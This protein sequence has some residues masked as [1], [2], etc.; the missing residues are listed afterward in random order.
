MLSTLA[1]VLDSTV[2]FP[3]GVIQGSVRGPLLYINDISKSNL[4]STPFL[5]SYDNK[6]V[7]LFEA[8]SFNSA[9]Q[10]TLEAF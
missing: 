1:A 8:G 4:H 6:I 5:F 3:N 7:C 10:L 9:F 2:P